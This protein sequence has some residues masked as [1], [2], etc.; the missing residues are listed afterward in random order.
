MRGKLMVTNSAHVKF[1]GFCLPG[2]G[3]NPS[4]RFNP[5]VLMLFLKGDSFTAF[6]S[7]GGGLALLIGLREKTFIP[8]KRK[9]QVKNI[10][11]G[12]TRARY[13]GIEVGV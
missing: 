4:V 13:G 2:V 6:C 9:N 7:L 10:H 8:R 11:Q 1:S 3:C 5:G 12:R